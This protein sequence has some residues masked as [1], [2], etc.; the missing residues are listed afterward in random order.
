[1]IRT[2][3]LDPMVQMAKAAGA[4]EEQLWARMGK[5][6]PIGR[7]GNPEEVAEAVTWLASD[8]ASFVTGVALPVD[9]GMA[10]GM[11]PSDSPF[12]SE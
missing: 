3:I 6:H 2:P 5:A 10:G 9:G 4:S 11:A 7:V 1:V 8:R 12:G